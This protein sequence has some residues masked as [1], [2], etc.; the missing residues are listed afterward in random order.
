MPRGAQ[1]RSKLPTCPADAPSNSILFPGRLRY[2]DYSGPDFGLRQN[3]EDGR[4]RAERKIVVGVYHPFHG[5][6][7]SVKRPRQLVRKQAV[8][9][10]AEAARRINYQQRPRRVRSV[11]SQ[12]ASYNGAFEWNGP[13]RAN[14]RG[15]CQAGLIAS[16]DW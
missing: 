4:I 2:R 13:I 14:A 11:A 16:D 6:A 8:G 7:T 15:F 9:L 1:S 10:A 5:P 3:P 12:N